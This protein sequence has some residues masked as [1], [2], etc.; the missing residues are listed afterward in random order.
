MLGFIRGGLFLCALIQH[1]D[2]ASQTLTA[3]EVIQ[4]M[5]HPSPQL[6]L[7][8]WKRQ[9]QLRLPSSPSHGSKCLLSFLCPTAANPHAHRHALSMQEEPMSPSSPHKASPTLPHRR[10]TTKVSTIPAKALPQA[11]PQV[12]LS[13]E[14]TRMSNTT[15]RGGVTRAIW[16]YSHLPFQSLAE[17]TLLQGNEEPKRTHFPL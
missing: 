10:I 16:S 11:A 6:L 17:D 2:K 1:W 5:G 8:P 4:A 9:H 12:N 15:C 13:T 3:T 7:L 14:D